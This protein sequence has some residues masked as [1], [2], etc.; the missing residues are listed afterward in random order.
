MNLLNCVLPPRLV[1]NFSSLVSSPEFAATPY[2]TSTCLQD[3]GAVCGDPLSYER[4]CA[5][6]P[7]QVLTLCSCVEYNNTQYLS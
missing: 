5:S 1:T 6:L 4:K 2:F 3:S 7:H